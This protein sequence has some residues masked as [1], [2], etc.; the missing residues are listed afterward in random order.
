MVVRY[1]ALM[2]LLLAGQAA[3]NVTVPLLAKSGS[4]QNTTLQ[5]ADFSTTGSPNDVPDV[6]P[7]A[8]PISAY[9]ADVITWMQG[10]GPHMQWTFAVASLLAGIFMLWDGE[11]SFKW[12]F[13]IFIFL[14]SGLTCH[15]ELLQVWEGSTPTCCYIAGVLFGLVVA[16][17][18]FR[19]YEGAKVALG[20]VLGVYMGYRFHMFLQFGVGHK[21]ANAPPTVAIGYSF[22][23]IAG[24]LLFTPNCLGDPHS[25]ALRIAAPIFGGAFVASSVGFICAQG[26]LLLKAHVPTINIDAAGSRW[27]DFVSALLGLGNGQVGVLLNHPITINGAAWSP[28]DLLGRFLWFILF[29]VGVYANVKR[30]KKKMMA[31]SK[32]FRGGRVGNSNAN[33]SNANARELEEPLMAQ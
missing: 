10:S 15:W 13:S 24:I 6:P 1:V 32:S 11:K 9:F 5:L 27:V 8:P 7:V 22:F 20:A 12:M 17:A 23:L 33:F 21:F 28:D 26:A 4:A 3:E 18:V 25:F 14:G 19:G 29:A 31:K 30:H 2:G 16:T